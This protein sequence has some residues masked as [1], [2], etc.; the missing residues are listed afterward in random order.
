MRMS[1]RIPPEHWP[2]CIGFSE[3]YFPFEQAPEQQPA[4]ERAAA[5]NE[6]WPEIDPGVYPYFAYQLERPQWS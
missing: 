5:A 4:S 2:D 1:D 3:W 6:F